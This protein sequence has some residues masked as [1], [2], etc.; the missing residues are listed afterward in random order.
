MGNGGANSPLD[1]HRRFAPIRRTRRF[2]RDLGRAFATQHRCKR[3]DIGT[4]LRRQWT[5][6]R[7]VPIIARRPGI[8]SGEHGV[9]VAIPVPHLTQIGRAGENVVMRIV[10]V[11][12]EPVAGTQFSPGVRHDLHQTYRARR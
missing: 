7:Q 10:G 8:V 5:A 11:A 6:G 2:Q 9:N 1:E 3:G 12:A 4:C